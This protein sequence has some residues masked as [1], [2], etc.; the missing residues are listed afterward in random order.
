MDEGQGYWGSHKERTGGEMGKQGLV[1]P[2]LNKKE[3]LKFS[4][5]FK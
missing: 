2:A 1:S 4:R 3:E 5:I